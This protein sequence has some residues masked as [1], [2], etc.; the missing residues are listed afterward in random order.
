MTEDRPDLVDF[1]VQATDGSIGK[2]DEATTSVD[3]SEIVVDTGPWIFGRRVIL[4]AGTIDRIDWDAEE[5]HV[6]LSKEQIKDSPELP[7]S[8][9]QDYRTTLGG[10][11]GGFYGPGPR[12]G[13]F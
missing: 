13:G 6:D 7:E 10:Y 3:A 4:P 12:P 8:V 11:Y 9:D 1:K 5:I 2:V